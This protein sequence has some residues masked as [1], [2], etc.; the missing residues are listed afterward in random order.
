MPGPQGVTVNNLAPGAILTARKRAQMAT[1]GQVLVQ[2][3]PPVGLAGQ[4]ISREQRCCCVRIPGRHI[5]GI[6]F[7]VDGGRAIA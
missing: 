4:T 1:E 5:N 7:Y 2:R 3:I 6:N